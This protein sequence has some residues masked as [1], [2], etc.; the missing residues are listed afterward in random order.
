MEAFVCT[1]FVEH[2]IIARVKISPL[3]YC[4]IAKFEGSLIVWMK[5]AISIRFEFYVHSIFRT[6]ISHGVLNMS[7]GISGLKINALCVKNAMHKTTIVIDTWLY[8]VFIGI[9]KVLYNFW[10]P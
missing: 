10:K 2:E 1:T 3:W 9:S 8:V 7:K 5:T 6:L 4:Y